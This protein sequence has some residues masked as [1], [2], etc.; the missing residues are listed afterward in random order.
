M[1]DHSNMQ[2]ED[3][4][5]EKPAR[6]GVGS[7]LLAIFFVFLLTTGALIFKFPLVAKAAFNFVT[8]PI[9]KI[10]SN[11][12][13]VNIL[14]MGNSGGTH[15]GAD[16]TDTMML[17]SISLNQFGIKIVSIPRDVW[18]PEIRA[19]INSAY[20]WGKSGSPYFDVSSTGGGIA[21]AKKIV[22]EVSGQ[23]IQY[24][25]VIDFSSFKDIVDTLGGIEVN[26]ENSFTDK[27]YPIAGREDDLCDG[28]RTFACRYETII[29]NSG[30]QKMDGET[31]LKFVRSRHAEGSEGTDIAREARQQK[32]ISAIKNKLVK[33]GTYLSLK[34]DLA[35]LGLIKKYVETDINLPTAGVLA[36]LTLE[37]SRNIKQLLIPEDLLVKPPTSKTYDNLYVFIPKLGNGKWEEVNKWFTS[38]LAN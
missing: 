6:K 4:R 2:E 28:D 1:L 21:F 8:K 15:A 25:L 17:V 3:G 37:G 35:M 14:V 31:A 22:G 18:V 16:L 34:K 27:L 10:S 12:G 32:I 20:Y 24:G 11:S 9:D 13:F 7:L 29:F 5:L 30:I 19:K 23:Q 26:V 38:I 33:P 36:R